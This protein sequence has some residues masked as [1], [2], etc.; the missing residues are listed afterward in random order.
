MTLGRM[1][2]NYQLCSMGVSLG[3]GV[4]SNGWFLLGKTILKWMMTGDTPNLGNHHM[5]RG[6]TYGN[7]SIFVAYIYR[8]Y[9]YVLIVLTDVTIW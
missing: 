9:G 6:G 1:G 5:Y 7:I 8:Y 4:P 3:I 2:I